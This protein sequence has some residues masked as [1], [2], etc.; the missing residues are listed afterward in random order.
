MARPSLG[1]LSSLIYDHTTE[2]KKQVQ[3]LNLLV[4]NQNN[5]STTVLPRGTGTG[6]YPIFLISGAIKVTAILLTCDAMEPDGITFGILLNGSPSTQPTIDQ[7]HTEG[8]ILIGALDKQLTPG[9]CV[10]GSGVLIAGGT[11]G[12]PVGL[13]LTGHATQAAWTVSLFWQGITSAAAVSC[14]KVNPP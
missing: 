13:R 5:Q 10:S 6:D 12:T 9:F 8:T 14:I 4:I 2:L 11:G 7:R 3:T 1:V